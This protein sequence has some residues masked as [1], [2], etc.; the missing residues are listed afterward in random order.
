MKPLEKKL[1]LIFIYD[2]FKNTVSNSYLVESNG[3][4]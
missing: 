3:G 1:D 2:L 4:K